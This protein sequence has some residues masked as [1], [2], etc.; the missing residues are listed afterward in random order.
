[1][2]FYSPAC[3]TAIDH[4]VLTGG[5]TATPGCIPHLFAAASQ[6][7]QATARSPWVEEI[8]KNHLVGYRIAGEFTLADLVAFQ[9]DAA[10]L[11]SGGGLN[12]KQMPAAGQCALC[13]FV[14]AADTTY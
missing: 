4:Q 5:F 12:E 13:G 6:R 10:A 1:L 3:I 11:N 14:L 2:F 8:C 9:F 7:F